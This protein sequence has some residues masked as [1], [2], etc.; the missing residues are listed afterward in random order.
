MT[1]S[2]GGA[3]LEYALFVDE[4]FGSLDEQT[5]DEV[6]DVLDGLRE[7]GRLVGIVSHVPH[8]RD[9]IPE[10]AARVSK[11]TSGSTVTQLDGAE[12]PDSRVGFC[13]L[14]RGRCRG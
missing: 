7:G 3:P 9:R 5:L 1:A 2:A 13:G 12:G 10:P 6:L 11:G 4:G 8:L 14:R